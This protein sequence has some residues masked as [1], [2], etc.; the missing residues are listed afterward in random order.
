[1]L[2]ALYLDPF[3]WYPEIIELTNPLLKTGALRDAALSGISR[4]LGRTHAVRRV[5]RERQWIEPRC[6]TI[7]PGAQ[8]SADI[9]TSSDNN[10]EGGLRR[11]L[12]RVVRRE[13]S[14]GE[15]GS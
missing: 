13:P 6:S 10:Q 11:P 2:S 14:L 12:I 1:A 9:E 8:D 7:F 5:G 3:Q 4:Y 15:H